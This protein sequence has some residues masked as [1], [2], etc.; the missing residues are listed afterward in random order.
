MVPPQQSP[1]GYTPVFIPDLPLQQ[2]N[3]SHPGVV[4]G[5]DE[6]GL[7]YRGRVG[8]D[9]AIPRFQNVPI[10]AGRFTAF[11]QQ[12]ETCAFCKDP[13]K[14]RLLGCAIWGQALGYGGG[15][16]RWGGGNSPGYTPS[17]SGL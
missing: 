3:N 4:I 6:P 13:G 16:V 7:W 5:G 15:P 14:E 10:P 8:G 17:A 9:S 12:I 1:S 2:Q 11:W